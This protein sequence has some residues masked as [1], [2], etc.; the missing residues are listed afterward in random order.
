[1]VGQAL[2]LTTAG[3]HT[4]KGVHSTDGPLSWLGPKLPRLICSEPGDL[5]QSPPCLQNH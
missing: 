5:P 3:Y 2:P 1:M 4:S